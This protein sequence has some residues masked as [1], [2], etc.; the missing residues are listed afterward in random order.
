MAVAAIAHPGEALAHGVA[1]DREHDREGEH[2]PGV[3]Q[4]D[5]RKVSGAEHG[6]EHA[7]GD[8]DDASVPNRTVIPATVREAELPCFTLRDVAVDAPAARAPL[9]GG[10]PSTGPPPRLRAPPTC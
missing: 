3:E 9:V 8:M 5:S 6:H 1:H 4:Q 7:L 2:R 10:D